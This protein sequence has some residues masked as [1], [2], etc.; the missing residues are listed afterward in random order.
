MSPTVFRLT[1]RGLLPSPDNNIYFTEDNYIRKAC[2][3]PNI[4]A[5]DY[6]EEPKCTQKGTGWVTFEPRQNHKR[7]LKKILRKRRESRAN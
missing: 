6:S 1:E 4:M 3:A 2:S 7:R 5:A